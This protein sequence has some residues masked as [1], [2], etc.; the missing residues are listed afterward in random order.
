MRITNTH[1]A[2]QVGISGWEIPSFTESFPL[3]QCMSGITT[4][5][6][7]DCQILQ[8]TIK[9]LTMVPNGAI[10]GFKLIIPNATMPYRIFILLQLFYQSKHYKRQSNHSVV[11]QN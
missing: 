5:L 8:K 7:Q 2:L 11:L 3:L 10:D 4:S 1:H 6:S 9:S